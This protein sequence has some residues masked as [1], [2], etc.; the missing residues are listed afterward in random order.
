MRRRLCKK[1]HLGEFREWGRSIV[2]SIHT[3]GNIADAVLDRFIK[4]IES[5][6]LDFGGSFES[7]D[8][9]VVIDGLVSRRNGSVAMP[10]VYSLVTWLY[11]NG[12]VFAT[13]SDPIDMHHGKCSWDWSENMVNSA[14]ALLV[15]KARMVKRIPT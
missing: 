13:A 7:Q 3:D 14:K 8:S 2:A 6:G 15:A 5:L 4:H 11:D 12:A 1:K 10:D 9:G